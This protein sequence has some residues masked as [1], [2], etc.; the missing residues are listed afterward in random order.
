MILTIFGDVHGNLVALEKMF[1]I[2][3]AQTDFFVCH[4]DVVNYGP[5]TKECIE[6]LKNIQNVKLLKG[7]HEKYFI[8]G[9]YD[10]TNIVAKAFFNHCFVNFDDELVRIISEYENDFQVNEFSIQ[11]TINNQY[12]F[13]DTNLSNLQIDRNY[14]IGHSHQQFELEKDNFK[15][16]NTGSLGQNRQFINQ[17]CYL[18]LDTETGKLEL[19]NFLHNIDLV[20]NQMKSARYPQICIDYYLLKNRI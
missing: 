16:Y 12:V 14:I 1:E 15:I 20:I 9:N 17:S 6:F 5:W 11:H 4:G 3:K 8:D 19:K 2:E 10:G 13:A 18:K 7:N